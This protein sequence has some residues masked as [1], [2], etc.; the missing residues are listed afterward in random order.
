MKTLI[1]YAS[2]YGYGKECAEKLAEQ[3]QG[4]VLLANILKESNPPIE[5]FDTVV[6]GGSIYIGQIQKKLKEYC[7]ANVEL[8]KNKRIALFLCS[9]APENLEKDMKNSFPE[10]LLQKAIAMEAFGGIINRDKL[11]LGHKLIMKM[12]D[13]AT[14][15][16][17]KPPMKQ[18]TENITK[19]AEAING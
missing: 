5:N 3:I 10:D 19:L 7:A 14:A 4:E 15:K 1:I 2:K 6:I 13:N 16:D 12:M 17:P 8:L 11:N 9:G 18:M